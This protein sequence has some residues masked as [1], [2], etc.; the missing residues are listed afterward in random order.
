M[1][2]KRRVFK[3]VDVKT[4]VILLIAIKIIVILFKILH[5]RLTTTR[6]FDK[7]KQNCKLVKLVL[8]ANFELI[9]RQL[10]IYR[11]RQ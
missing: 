3:A 9:F 10:K 11:K 5:S 8:S 1:R 6:F 4:S 7:K 2:I